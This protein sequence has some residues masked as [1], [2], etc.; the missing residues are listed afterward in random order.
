MTMPLEPDVGSEPWERLATYVGASGADESLLRDAWD[1]AE[2]MV[3]DYIGA[4][5]VPPKILDLA[6]I[7]TGSEL[8]ARRS[9]PS[10]IAQYATGDMNPVRLARD[11]MT[12]TYPM[13]RR[14]VGRGIA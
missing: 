9:A 7:Q 5:T 8:F 13:L 3:T 10:G 1:Q 4:V 14:Y 11:P 2:V 6:I 12:G